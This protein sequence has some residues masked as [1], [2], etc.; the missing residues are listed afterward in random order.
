MCSR[1]RGLRRHEGESVSLECFVDVR[2]V[3]TLDG[4]LVCRGPLTAPVHDDLELFAWTKCRLEG[5][6]RRARQ[7]PIAGNDAQAPGRHASCGTRPAVIPSEWDSILHQTPMER[8]TI[9]SVA[10]GGLTT[11]F[12]P[13]A[14]TLAAAPA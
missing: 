1:L 2:V 12:L 4:R 5:C 3:A 6:D 11:F 7:R 13:A 9:H 14:L 8:W 10:A